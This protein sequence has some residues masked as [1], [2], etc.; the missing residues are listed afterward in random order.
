MATETDVIELHIDHD[1]PRAEALEKHYRAI[2]DGK[3]LLIWG[4]V[5]DADLE[6]VLT[7]LPHRGLAVNMVVPSVEAAHQ[8]WDRA[9]NLASTSTAVRTA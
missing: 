7:R 6:F 9:M 5:T 3:P 1:G 4:D 2:L 8:A